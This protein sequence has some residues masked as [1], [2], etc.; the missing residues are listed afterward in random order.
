ML[1]R[2][3]LG[4]AL[5]VCA[6][7][8]APAPVPFQAE[9]WSAEV[10]PLKATLF[11]AMHARSL[12]VATLTSIAAPT[13]GGERLDR[14]SG[15]PRVES[16]V[17][18]ADWSPA[19]PLLATGPFTR[20]WAEWLRDFDRIDTVEHHT[21]EVQGTTD[22]GIDQLTTVESVWV[23][24]TARDGRRREDRLSLTLEFTRGD[25]WRLQSLGAR[26]GRTALAPGPA[27]ADITSAA[28]PPGHDQVGTELYTDGGPAL[29]DIDGDGDVD[30][31]LPRLHAPAKLYLNDGD[32]RFEDATHRLGLALS[33]LK[34]GTNSGLLFDADGDGDIDLLVGIKEAG[35][36]LLL[37]DGDRFRRAHAGLL[38]GPGQWESLAAA[39]FDNDGRIDVYACNYGLIDA[40]H[41]PGSYIDAVD[42]LPNVLLRNTADGFI[43]AT[44]RTGLD[45]D[46]TRWSYAASWAD[47]D[48][49]GDMD[50]YVANDYGPNALYRNDGGRFTQI[51][52]AA[53]AQDQGNG[54]SAL[55][56]DHDGD[57]WLDLYV[58]N[59]QSFA[60][61]R[62]TRLDDF[63]GTA[64]ERA[65]YS[66]FAQGNSLLRNRGDGTFEDVTVASGAKPAFWAWG[67]VA[68]DADA[69][70]DEDLFC[71]AGMYT[72]ARA[73]D[74]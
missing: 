19:A 15:P 28:L 6:C 55:W 72:G 8:P 40:T 53:G 21:W 5:L 56:F 46:A 23:A 63:P 69:D 27:F 25:A 74:T 18:L 52:A 26:N 64:A 20:S 44:A 49:D 47:F 51:A 54:M 58:S 9:L 65:I 57:G 42:G 30:L 17:S 29:A 36:L 3:L 10:G 11:D 67:A 41:Q 12:D 68:L 22:H 73:A 16:G 32:A 37:R 50:L 59:M 4:L 39:D 43:D 1:R 34:T 13:F 33:V 60:G 71:S 2:I 66:R 24:G 45:V 48:R 62:L 14:R 7:A 35:L 31:F 38:A 70:G 61:N